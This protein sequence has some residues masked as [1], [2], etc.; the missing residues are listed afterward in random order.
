M[1]LLPKLNKIGEQCHPTLAGFCPQTLKEI[2]A[3]FRLGEGVRA[4][5]PS[6]PRIYTSPPA[7]TTSPPMILIMA[8][9]FKGQ[10]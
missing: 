4:C 6:V 2:S 9:P 7:H 3:K 1:R 5:G 8:R 10:P